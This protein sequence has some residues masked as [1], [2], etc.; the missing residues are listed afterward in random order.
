MIPTDVVPA[1]RRGYRLQWEPVQHAHVVLY[2]EGMVK[3]N[4]SAAEILLQVNGESTAGAIVTALQQKFPEAGD[5]TTDVMAFLEVA[6]DQ[7]WLIL[8]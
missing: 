8:R 3:L 7:Q 6:H 4:D 1:F 5:L 2:P